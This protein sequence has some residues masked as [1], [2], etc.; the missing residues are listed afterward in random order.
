[1]DFT[2]LTLN[3][4]NIIYKN[5][6]ELFKGVSGFSKMKKAEKIELLKSVENLNTSLE[7]IVKEKKIVKKRKPTFNNLFINFFNVDKYSSNIADLKEEVDSEI[8]KDLIYDDIPEFIESLD[9]I[10]IKKQINKY[11][12]IK[13]LCDFNG[14]KMNKSKYLFQKT[15]SKLKWSE[16]FENKVYVKLLEYNLLNI[17]ILINKLVRAFKKHQVKLETEAKKNKNNN[18]EKEDYN[19]EEDNIDYNSSDEEYDY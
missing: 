11:G 2:K 3:N 1:M 15:G 9:S 7:L 13:A 18:E 5:N 10:M 19:S 16:D 14:D 8:I 6:K 12:F 4:I 17:E